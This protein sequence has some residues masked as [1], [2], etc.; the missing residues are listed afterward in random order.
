MKK[1]TKKAKRRHRLRNLKALRRQV[2]NSNIA[3]NPNH[4]YSAEQLIKIYLNRLAAKRKNVLRSLL[5]ECTPVNAG[6]TEVKLKGALGLELRG[7]RQAFLDQAG[8]LIDFNTT[9]LCLDMEQ[10]TRIWPSAITQLCSLAQWVGFRNKLIEGPELTVSSTSSKIDHVNGYLNHCGFHD[11]VGRPPLNSSVDYPAGE[12]VKI[13]REKNRRKIEDTEDRIAE[14]VEKYCSYSQDEVELLASKILIEAFL[15]VH[16]HG[17]PDTDYGW[18]VLAQ[19]HPTN[20]L[21]S[22]NIADNGI[23]IKNTMMTGPQETQLRK[24]IGDP[25]LCDG[26]LIKA[27]MEENVSGAFNASTKEKGFI[28]RKY[29]RGARRGNG[30]A[31]IWHTCDQLG[32]E[33]T[34]LSH[35]GY[36]FCCGKTGSREFGTSEKRLFAGTLYQFSIPMD[37]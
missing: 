6:V 4:L 29:F 15:N 34:I 23:G 30:L 2:K 20:R 14:L 13:E 22:L 35:F 16:E 26:S 3:R 19:V 31:R 11:Y 37:T 9:E 27:S 24:S 18:W 25:N 32:I 21:I 28:I 1:I 33:F 7:D 12:V 36:M 5:R 10:V 17:I 8:E